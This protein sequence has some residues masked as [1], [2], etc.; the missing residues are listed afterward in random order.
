M[1]DGHETIRRQTHVNN[2]DQLL[3]G[4]PTPHK[5]Y[6]T[7]YAANWGQHPI[8]IDEQPSKVVILGHFGGDK[9]DHVYNFLVPVL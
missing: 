8:L 9:Y 6:V 3:A 4:L 1:V 5:D 7:N 2:N